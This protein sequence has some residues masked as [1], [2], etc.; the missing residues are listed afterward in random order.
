MPGVYDEFFG[1]VQVDGAGERWFS[2]A[3]QGGP[4]DDQLEGIFEVLPALP[5]DPV[6]PGE[7]VTPEERP[8]DDGEYLGTS[9]LCAARPGTS[10]GTAGAWLLVAMG[11]LMAGRRRRR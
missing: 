3:G 2:D 8:R 10:P 11:T 6:E 4:P 7:P 5:G 9:G 1:L